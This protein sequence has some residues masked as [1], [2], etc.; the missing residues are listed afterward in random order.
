MP[1][2]ATVEALAPVY[3]LI[4]CR[5]ATELA[6]A[7][8]LVRPVR[9]DGMRVARAAGLRDHHSGTLRYPSRHRCDC[10]GEREN[11]HTTFHLNL[12]VESAS[13]YRSDRARGLNFCLDDVLAV[14]ACI[15]QTRSRDMDGAMTHLPYARNAVR[16]GAQTRG[17][18]VGHFLVEG[19]G[20]QPNSGPLVVL[21]A[22][23][24]LGARRAG[25]PAR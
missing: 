9:H 22:V 23:A 20:D 14:L 2:R 12:R 8:A 18:L 15:T 3:P 13:P 24:L 5:A 1:I 10:S 16:D 17:R 11:R 21:M 6:G 4:G 7:K 25:A 19:R